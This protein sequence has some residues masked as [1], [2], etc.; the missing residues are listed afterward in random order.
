LQSV[1]LYIYTLLTAVLLLK[2]EFQMC[3][4]HNLRTT[5]AVKFR[6]MQKFQQISAEMFSLKRMYNMSDLN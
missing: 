3:R 5:I 1:L 2:T 6:K 4:A